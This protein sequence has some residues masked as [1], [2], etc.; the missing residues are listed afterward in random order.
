MAVVPVEANV[1]LIS[2]QIK[3]HDNPY[4]IQILGVGIKASVL[5][6]AGAQ[7][8]V[9]ELEALVQVKEGLIA[10]TLIR[11]VPVTNRT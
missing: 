11:N 4:R 2:F 5:F 6:V 10:V 9:T 7:L 8:I 3:I 1:G